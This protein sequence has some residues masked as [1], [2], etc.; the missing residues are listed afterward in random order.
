MELWFIVELEKEKN[1]GFL[2]SSSLCSLWHLRFF[3]FFF[4][5]FGVAYGEEGNRFTFSFFAEKVISFFESKLKTLHNG[6]S[7][8]STVKIPFLH[9]QSPHFPATQV[10]LLNGDCHLKRTRRIQFS[11][12]PLQSNVSINSQLYIFI[13]SLLYGK[14]ESANMSKIVLY[15]QELCPMALQ[16]SQCPLYLQQ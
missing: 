14:Q 16:S 12:L 11:Y 4:F 5:F 1:S 9:P 6:I 3:F 8:L 15:L 13:S 7:Y 10:Q 2:A